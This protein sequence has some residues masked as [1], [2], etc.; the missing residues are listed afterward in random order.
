MAKNFRLTALNNK[1]DKLES[2]LRQTSKTK[3]IH[4]ALW[5]HDGNRTLSP[6]PTPHD[7]PE[8]DRAP[9]YLINFIAIPSGKFIHP[10]IPPAPV[11]PNGMAMPVLCD[12]PDPD[13]IF[14]QVERLRAEALKELEEVDAAKPT[15][16]LDANANNSGGKYAGMTPEEI[17]V[18]KKIDAMT[19][20]FM[21]ELRAKQE[22]YVP[23]PLEPFD[24]SKLVP[25]VAKSRQQ[26]INEKVKGY[27]DGG[28]SALEAHRLARSEVGSM[29]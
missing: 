11:G 17:E 28:M 24:M 6:H 8:S 14:S 10:T 9:N 13:P 19:E 20:G 21:E 12:A 27:M 3:C 4:F 25:L 18:R 23:A 1:L 22:A 2:E 29:Q 26:L 5:Q 16:Q 7:N 15:E